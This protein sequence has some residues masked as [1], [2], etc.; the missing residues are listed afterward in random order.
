MDIKHLLENGVLTLIPDGR[1]DSNN[2]GEVEE[3]FNAI[4]KANPG[5]ELV[6]DADRLA[7]MSSA[8]LRIVL[9]LKKE[10]RSL[11]VINAS[12]ELYDVFEMTGFT[13]MM[14]IQ[15]AY[16][17]L[18]VEG[19]EQIGQGS[20]GIVYRLD[21][22]TIIKVYRNPD[23]LP[24]IHREREL[25]RKALILGIPTA[26]PYDVVK[27]GNSYGSV[28]ELLNATSYA[29]IVKNE[30]ERMEEMIRQ[31]VELMKQIHSTEIKPGDMPPEKDVV[32]KWVRD[33]KPVLSDEQYE[34]L[35]GLVDAVPDRN[36]MLHG[37]YHFKNVMVQNGE[38]LL[39]DMDTLC[40]GHPVFELA[41]VFNAYVG[42]A[43]VHPEVTLD[44]LG[45][46]VDTCKQI[47]NRV[48][49]LYF[50]TTDPAVLECNA[51]KAKLVGFTRLLRR[52]IRRTPD[53]K[54][55]IDYCKEQVAYLLTVVDTLE[56]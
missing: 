32:L 30:P 18:S 3:K 36:T 21:P 12:S 23:S 22:D 10:N 27:V 43:V 45:L 52:T 41:S 33:L 31:F 40:T 11:K 35:Y 14:E 26:I 24:D 38:T 9:R 37:D 39:I 47:W 46:P 13:E 54:A 6:I 53:D 1:I 5:N 51:N 29:K 44:F 16:R 34:K 50:D 19:C 56:F 17:R 15:K 8:G 42:F 2:A 28:F 25:A 48:L 20:N 7:Y 55:M 4:V 49:E